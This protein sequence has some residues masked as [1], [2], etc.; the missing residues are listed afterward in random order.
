MLPSLHPVLT[1]LCLGMGF[2]FYGGKQNVT[3]TSLLNLQEMELTLMWEQRW[4][5][6]IISGLN[7]VS[8]TS[9]SETV[10]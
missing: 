4:D 8:E 2:G 1:F 9:P 3:L 7:L 6:W 5:C 10:C